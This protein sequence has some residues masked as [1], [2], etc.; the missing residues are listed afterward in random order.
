MVLCPRPTTLARLMGNDGTE[1]SGCWTCCFLEGHNNIISTMTISML[2]LVFDLEKGRSLEA[3][4]SKTEGH[5]I[6]LLCSKKVA[7]CMFTRWADIKFN[8]LGGRTAKVLRELL[9]VRSLSRLVQKKAHFECDSMLLCFCS[10]QP[11][12]N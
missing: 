6:L 12:E 2:V 9:C 11:V 10:R 7:V 3:W 1:S 8:C 4:C 5:G